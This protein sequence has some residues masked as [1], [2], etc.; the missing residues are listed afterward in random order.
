MGSLLLWTLSALLDQDPEAQGSTEA[1]AIDPDPRVKISR[2]KTAYHL[3]KNCRL[4]P[5]EKTSKTGEIFFLTLV[6]FKIKLL[7]DNDFIHFTLDPFDS[8]NLPKGLHV[9]SQ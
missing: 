6:I 4:N 2:Q 1:R 5:I 3:L 9:Y 7:D 8:L